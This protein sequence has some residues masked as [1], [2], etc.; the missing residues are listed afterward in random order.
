MLAWPKCAEQHMNRRFGF[1]SSDS[2]CSCGSMVLSFKMS[3]ELGCDWLWV[4]LQVFG[5]HGESGD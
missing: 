3:Q 4:R 1:F 5:G 2:H